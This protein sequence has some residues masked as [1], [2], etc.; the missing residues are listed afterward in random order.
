MVEEADRWRKCRKRYKSRRSRNKLA[1]SRRDKKEWL[2]KEQKIVQVAKIYEPIGAKYRQSRDEGLLERSAQSVS[3]TYKRLQSDFFTQVWLM[4]AL[5]T[6][7]IRLLY[8]LHAGV[9][10]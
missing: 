6:K 2:H 9:S 1:K 3:G 7:Q 10:T 5:N 8:T 4:T